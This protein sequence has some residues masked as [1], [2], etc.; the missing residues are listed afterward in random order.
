M[1]HYG[2]SLTPQTMANVA[3]KPHML[4]SNVMHKWYLFVT[5]C[6]VCLSAACGVCHSKNTLYYDRI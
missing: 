2:L 4:C 3:V 1:D 6:G 5:L